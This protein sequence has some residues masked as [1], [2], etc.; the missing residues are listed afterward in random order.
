M[1]LTATVFILTLFICCVPLLIW[2]IKKLKKQVIML[3]KFAID[4]ND[5]FIVISK[6][7]KIPSEISSELLIC[8]KKEQEQ[9]T[10]TSNGNIINLNDFRK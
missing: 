10:N 9:S 4:A 8:K 6:I 5:N 2:E 1:I 7:C 3:T